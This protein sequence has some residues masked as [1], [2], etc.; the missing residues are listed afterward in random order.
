MQSIDMAGSFSAVMERFGRL[1]VERPC[2]P[3]NHVHPKAGA[4]RNYPAFLTRRTIPPP[5]TECQSFIGLQLG[6]IGHQRYRSKG[7]GRHELRKRGA[8]RAERGTEACGLAAV[9]SK[10]AFW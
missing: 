7:K 6:A 5:V 9:V 4:G 8:G 10:W 1:Q 2:L 3:Y